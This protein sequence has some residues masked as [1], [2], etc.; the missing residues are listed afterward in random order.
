MFQLYSRIII[1]FRKK[2][3]NGTQ[4]D[5]F[6]VNLLEP[7]PLSEPGVEK[8]LGICNSQHSLMLM[9]KIFPAWACDLLKSYCDI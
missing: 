3:H 4:S 9:T 5:G 1:Y 8:E 2:K 7:F 6:W